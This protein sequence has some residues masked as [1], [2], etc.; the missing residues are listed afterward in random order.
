MP[1][2]LFGIWGML[3]KQKILAPVVSLPLWEAEELAKSMTTCRN[4]SQVWKD[5]YRENGTMSSLIA[6]RLFLKIGNHL[7]CSRV[8]FL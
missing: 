4:L 7:P 8:Y 5:F 2:P 3:N 1:C 6:R